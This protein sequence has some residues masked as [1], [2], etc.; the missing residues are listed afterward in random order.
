MLRFIP[1]KT[2]ILEKEHFKWFGGRHV[3]K[4]CV[5]GLGIGKG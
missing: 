3:G 4:F 5:G 1:V 2:Q